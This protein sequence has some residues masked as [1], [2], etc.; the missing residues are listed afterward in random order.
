MQAMLCTFLL[1]ACLANPNPMVEGCGFL[2]QPAYA[3]DDE[4]RGPAEP[5]TPKPGDIVLSTDNL[6][7]WQVLFNMAFTG[8]PH[9]SGII[10]ARPDGRLG[11]LEAGPHDTFYVRLLDVV[12]HLCSYADD[13][14]VWIRRR[15]TPLTP[16]QSARLTAWATAQDGKRFA[17]LRLGVQLTPFRSRGPLRTWI[18]GGPHGERCSYFCAE[19]VMESCV[20]A[21]LLDPN[22]TRPAATYPR[23]FFFDSSTN[24][25][26]NTHLNLSADWYPPARWLRQPETDPPKPAP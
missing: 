23:D 16:E 10:V 19:L 18:M 2:C 6:I 3:L 4:R 15:R 20:R 1:S 24:W 8:H 5:Y 11:L 7:V 9:H 12:P 14:R 25:Y 21:G 13:G 17:L 26:N 22:R